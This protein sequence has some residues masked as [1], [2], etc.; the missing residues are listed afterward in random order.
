V[1]GD[2]HRLRQVVSNLVANALTHTPAGTPVRLLVTHEPATARNGWRPVARAGAP[3]VFTGEVGMLE[4]HDDGPGIPATEA[5]HLFDRFYRADQAGALRRGS[6][7]GLAISAAILEAHQGR[8]ELN[9]TPGQGTTF[10]VVLPL[11]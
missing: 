8:I 3:A 10:R 1:L 9:S 11:A 6:G 2:E 4:V 5:P 7:L